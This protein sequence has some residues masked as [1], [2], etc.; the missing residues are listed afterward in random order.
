M[1][2][3]S[4]VDSVG[5]VTEPTLRAWGLAHDFLHTDEDLPVLRAAFARAQSLEAPVAVMVTGDTT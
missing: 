3:R 2:S 4:D 5:L 1:L